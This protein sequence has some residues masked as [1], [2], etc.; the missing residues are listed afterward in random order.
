MTKAKTNSRLDDYIKLI[1]DKDSNNVWGVFS[2]E[3]DTI[4]GNDSKVY[5]N[6]VRIYRVENVKTLE[7]RFIYIMEEEYVFDFLKKED[8]E[9][10]SISNKE[11]ILIGMKD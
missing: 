10:R 3:N 7:K 4:N 11:A 9:Y 2:I 5:G 6:N 1:A 8:S